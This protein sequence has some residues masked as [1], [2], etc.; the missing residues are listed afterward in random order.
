MGVLAAI[1][2]RANA[3]QPGRAR[4]AFSGA[5]TEQRRPLTKKGF[6][7]LARDYAPYVVGRSD[8]FLFVIS[9]SDSHMNKVFWRGIKEQAVL[10]RAVAQL[11]RVGVDVAGTLFVEVGANIGTTTLT[12]LRAGFGSVVAFEPEPENFRLLRANLVLN[13]AEEQV[14]AVQVAVSD[15]AGPGRFAVVGGKSGAHHLLGADEQTQ[16][17]AATVRVTCL[18]DLAAEG[19]LDPQKIG[20]LWIDVEG[21]EA[22]VLRGGAEALGHDF[23]VVL[24]VNP[25]ALGRTGERD[26]LLALLRDRFTHFVDLRDDDGVVLTADTLGGLFGTCERRGKA[27]DVLAFNVSS[28][29]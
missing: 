25:D 26:G 18:D 4:R 24:E 16:W 14:H 22:H 2:R 13:E 23:P 29:T 12:A 8:G 9:T 5:G 21:Y 11:A 10:N 3:W 1:W 20:L 19:T 6:F 17:Q 27:T 7:G 28:S 15:R